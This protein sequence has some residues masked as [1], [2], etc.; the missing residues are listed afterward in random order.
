MADDT[1][2]DPVCDMDV[3]TDEAAATVDHAGRTYYFCSVGCAQE[4][5]EHPDAYA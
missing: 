5:R 2:T 4:F 1:A 3:A